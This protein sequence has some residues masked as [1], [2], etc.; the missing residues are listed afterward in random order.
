MHP[1]DRFLEIL[2]ADHSDQ[3]SLRV[4]DKRVPHPA[5]PHHVLEHL[6]G[7]HVR[8]KR[9][10]S[11][12]HGLLDGGVRILAEVVQP[13]PPQDDSLIVHDHTLVPLSRSNLLV[14][15]DDTAVETAGGDIAAG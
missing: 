5:T 7:A 4:S 9:G 13:H 2:A 12:H 8:P 6:V 14:Y 15:V 11:L 10:G 3:P 1:M